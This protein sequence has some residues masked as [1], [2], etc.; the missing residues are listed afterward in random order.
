M[1]QTYFGVKQRGYSCSGW[2]NI[3][4]GQPRSTSCALCLRF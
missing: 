4:Q 3:L 1:C 2:N